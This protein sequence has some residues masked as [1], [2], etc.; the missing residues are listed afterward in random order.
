MRMPP[1]VQGLAAPPA[2]R[3]EVVDPQQKRDPALW[4]ACQDFEAIFIKQ[5]LSSARLGASEGGILEPDAGAGVLRDMHNSTL[6]ESISRSRG[7]GLAQII[8]RSLDR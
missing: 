1:P 2:A 7:L 5:L 3:G 8:S 4:R 6:A